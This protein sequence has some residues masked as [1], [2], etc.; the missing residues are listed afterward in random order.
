M[1]N[2][3]MFCT[4]FK[5]TLY[6]GLMDAEGLIHCQGMMRL[7]TGKD[8]ICVQKDQRVLENPAYGVLKILSQVIT[9][10]G[11]ISEITPELL[12]QLFLVDMIYLQKFFNNINQET[13]EISLSGE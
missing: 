12:E 2:N 13:M 4:E 10:I 7:P 5:F 11:G 1:E 6:K 8:E 9:Y 3:K